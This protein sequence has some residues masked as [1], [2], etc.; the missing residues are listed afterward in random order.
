MSDA[1]GT[2]RPHATADPLGLSLSAEASWRQV[3]TWTMRFRP[4]LEG[5][6]IAQHQNFFE[7]AIKQTYYC[8]L[9][10][11]FGPTFLTH[12]IGADIAAET[13]SAAQ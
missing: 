10:R 7:A 3:L 4:A 1:R 6:D 8:H 11:G 2:L 12:A 5:N 9:A 13:D